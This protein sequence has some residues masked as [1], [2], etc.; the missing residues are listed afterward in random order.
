MGKRKKKM[1]K[2]FLS[3]LKTEE[4]RDSCGWKGDSFFSKVEITRNRLNKDIK[5]F[6]RH[7]MVIIMKKLFMKTKIV[8]NNR[9]K[10][11]IKYIQY[12]L[13]QQ[14]VLRKIFE[15]R[16]NRNT[17][18]LFSTYKLLFLD[19]ANSSSDP[20]QKLILQFPYIEL[21]CLPHHPCQIEP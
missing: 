11:D 7:S 17:G 10:W 6:V 16:E 2:T 19:Q 21:P 9:K 8:A 12:Y 3:K 4:K 18:K 15:T 14:K 20:S 13:P 5:N 1:I